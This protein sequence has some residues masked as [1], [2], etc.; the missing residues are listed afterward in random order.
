M[1]KSQIGA[2]EMIALLTM[3]VTTNAFLGYP[4]AISRSGLEAAWMEPLLSGALALV[5][6]IIVQW[7]IRRYFRGLDFIEI[8]K[9]SFGRGFAI[10]VALLCVVYLVASTASVMREFEENVITTVLPT[11]PILLVGL[12]YIV[13]VW[14]MAY[15]GLE[16]IARTSLILLPILFVGI[17]AVCLLTMNWWRP[18]L[19]LPFWGAGTGAIEA[20][21]L[22]YA[23]VFGNVL[24]LCIIYP[25]AHNPKSFRAIGIIS[26]MLAALLLG[27]FEA[28][29]HMVFGPIQA[30]K[31]PFH[32][33]QL[34]RMIYLGRFFQ[35]MESIFV[36]LWVTSA[37]VKM[38]LTLWA[39]AY[40]LGSAFR[41][42]VIRPI[43]PA[44]A[45]ICF[46]CSMIPK[47]VMD[48]VRWEQ[49]YLLAW[50]WTIVFALPCAV[51]LFGSLRKAGR[52]R[53]VRDA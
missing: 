24:L 41:W 9:E 52:R 6:F 50:G 38:A 49:D 31:M 23:S 36:F 2:R 14:Y 4:E 45:L 29:F 21:S 28:V 33:Y 30:S 18:F 8:A 19:L 13:A 46:C 43:L 37:V 53:A 39:S 34:A 32:L 10:I 12:L 48:A 47:N 27:G 42:P 17:F 3:F 40:L 16:G 5:L 11:T 25:H 51:V 1:T 44:L 35:R 22:R 15:C 7:L 26:I 20:G